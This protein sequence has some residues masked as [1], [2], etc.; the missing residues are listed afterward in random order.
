METEYDL[1]PEV[2]GRGSFGEVKLCTKKDTQ[3]QRVAKNMVKALVSDQDALMDEVTIQ[4]DLDHPNICRIFDFF[5]TPTE[6]TL[7]LEAC[8]GGDL[9]DAILHFDNF[10]QA[11]A[12]HLM[13]QVLLAVNYM[14]SKNIVHR[15]LKPEN[16]LLKE[17]DTPHL[18]NQLKVADFGFAR[19][20]RPGLRDLKTLC[21]T[22]H[23]LA[24]EIFVGNAYDEKCDLWSCGVILYFFLSG[25][26]PF[27]GEDIDDIM[28]AAQDKQ[29]TFNDKVWETVSPTAKLAVAQML[30]KAPER[31][32]SAARALQS[33]WFNALLDGKCNHGQEDQLRSQTILK[34]L[35]S[36]QQWSCL[37]QIG[38]HLIAH[39]LPD[40]HKQS[41]RTTF[42][43]LDKNGDGKLSLEEF[44]K[45]LGD[46][47][48]HADIDVLFRLVDTDGSG[49]VEWTEFL[50]VLSCDRMRSCQFACK[51]AFA[52]FDVDRDGKVSFA[53]LESMMN[54]NV[55]KCKKVMLEEFRLIDKD[56][57]GYIDLDEFTELMTDLHC[58][59]KAAPDPSPTGEGSSRDRIGSR[60]LRLVWRATLGPTVCSSSVAEL[61]PS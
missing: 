7:V 9:S 16:F 53:E 44:K 20:F 54:R 14:H 29:P 50:A 19:D 57:D 27:D 39:N 51:E 42:E 61:A 48:H 36:F 28:L 13:K 30:N 12:Q 24:P 59:G 60:W 55:T 1:S 26:V 21:G 11:D 35:K 43:N 56:G 49:F 52:V 33:P 23:F 8:R 38:A 31:R 46:Y 5:E 41:I 6:I 15:D 40:A 4:C 34:R 47:A 10:S 18:R 25:D 22:S 37:K 3:C 58:S 32:F 17:K 45:G 2:L